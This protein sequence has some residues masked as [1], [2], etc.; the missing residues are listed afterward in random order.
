MVKQDQPSQAGRT[1][2]LAGLQGILLEL[3]FEAF[4]E[5]DRIGGRSGKS[6]DHIAAREMTH[7]AGVRLDDACP[8]LTC[9]SPATTTRLP[10]RRLKIVV[11][12][13]P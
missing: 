10:L 4:E 9:P 12:C 11:P 1:T 5:G 2:T 6:P 8:M 13:H 3:R 7:L